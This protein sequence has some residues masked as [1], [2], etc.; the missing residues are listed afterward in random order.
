[1]EIAKTG[2]NKLLRNNSVG[3]VLIFNEANRYEESSVGF[4][5]V[6][7]LKILNKLINSEFFTWFKYL[8]RFLSVLRSGSAWEHNGLRY[9]KKNSRKFLKFL[10]NWCF[11]QQ[12]EVE[13]V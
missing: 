3:F 2:S 1:M 7:N 11:S 9:L 4:A 6:W 13:P 10:L 8:N 5:C 12:I